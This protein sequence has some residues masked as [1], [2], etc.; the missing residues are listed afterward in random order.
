MNKRIRKKKLKQRIKRQEQF[1]KDLE[2]RKETP[3][4]GLRI[5]FVKM[6]CCMNHAKLKSGDY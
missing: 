4:K 2:R 1:I 5:F 6:A 3:F